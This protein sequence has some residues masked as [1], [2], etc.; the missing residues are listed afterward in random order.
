MDKDEFSVAPAF[1]L[2]QSAEEA[3]EQV[4][5]DTSPVHGTYPKSKQRANIESHHDANIGHLETKND[6]DAVKRRRRIH[7]YKSSSIDAATTTGT[8]QTKKIIIITRR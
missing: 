5:T 4:G 3:T 1:I 2:K 7:N 6:P 8:T